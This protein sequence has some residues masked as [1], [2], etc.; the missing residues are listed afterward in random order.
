[1]VA[2]PRPAVTAVR[3][4]SVCFL[5]TLVAG[6]AGSSRQSNM[7][8][9]ENYFSMSLPGIGANP[10]MSPI[11]P[12]NAQLLSQQVPPPTVVR[13]ALLAQHQRWAGTPYRI[14]GTSERGIDCSALVRKGYRDTFNLEWPR[15][16]RGQVHEGRSIDR[17][18][19]QAGDL[20]FFSPP[21]R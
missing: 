7:Q 4:A 5:V 18:E 13:E 17:Q 15:S 2:L 9:P 3:V 20:V 21:G 10:Q 16:T 11:D 1:M 6:C 19:L 8:A 14:G 12:I